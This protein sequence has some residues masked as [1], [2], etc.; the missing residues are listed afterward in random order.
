MPTFAADIMGSNPLNSSEIQGKMTN[1]KTIKDLLATIKE[2]EQTVEA[3]R[4]QEMLPASFFNH[5][6]SLTYQI[7]K[8]LQSLEELQIEALRKQME[9]HQR[10]IES[11]PQNPSITDV[12]PNEIIPIP[13]ET[14]QPEPTE[15]VSSISQAQETVP[16]AEPIEQVTPMAD[17]PSK[18]LNDL[19]EK[20][21]LSD[22]RKAFTL[23]DRFRFRREL[24]GNND[25]AMNKAIMDLNGFSSYEDSIAYIINV[26]GWDPENTAVAD[27]IKLLEKRFL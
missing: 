24:F 27:F 6:F 4:G 12:E 18:S 8:G 17:T 21:Q 13:E 25:E 22:F 9:E 5:T 14:P 7:A 23:N 10:L 11:I 19:L 16:I 3:K 15:E 2:L 20:R 26:L 1:T